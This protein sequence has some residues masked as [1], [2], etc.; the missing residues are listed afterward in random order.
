MIDQPWSLLSEKVLGIKFGKEESYFLPSVLVAVG[1]VACVSGV[2]EAEGSPDGTGILV[3]GP[4]GLG[5]PHQEAPV[6]DG[7]GLDQYVRMART[8]AHV[9]HQSVVEELSLVLGIESLC[10]GSGQVDELRPDHHELFVDN[11][12]PDGGQVEWNPGDVRFE[13]GQGQLELFDRKF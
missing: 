11:H 3:A 5:W 10:V 13:D 2:C 6:S 9:R 4:D 8:R 1:A 7:V 12:L